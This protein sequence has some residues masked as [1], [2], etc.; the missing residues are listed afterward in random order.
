[1]GGNIKCQRRGRET[2][3]GCR[4]VGIVYTS[5]CSSAE[6]SPNSFFLFS[7]P[8][9]SKGTISCP[10]ALCITC[11]VCDGCGF[12]SRHCPPLVKRI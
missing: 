11:W 7:S 5:L 2:F 8:K 4:A 3:L 1:M 10:W 6:S 9:L 12:R